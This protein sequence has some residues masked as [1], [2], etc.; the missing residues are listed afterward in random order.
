MSSASS[1]SMQPRRF[2]PSGPLKGTIRVPG[3]KSISHRSI[4]FGALAV[5]DTRISGLL[6]GEDV[7]ATAAAM[8][9]M[10]ARV[11]RIG[12]G[13]W[14]VSG[15]GVGSLLQ[16][17]TALDMGNSGTSTRLLM[18]LVASHPITASFIGDA[19]L[20]KRPMGRV[21]EPLG[22][23]GA[24]FTTSPGGTL[25]LMVRGASPAVPITEPSICAR[26]AEVTVFSE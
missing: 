16:P 22:K 3:D 21:T 18:G 17:E 9:A 8:R 13:D 1:A 10:G 6:E 24:D 19:S 7:M 23:M 15:V 20:S 14:R 2:L 26:A 4:M 25:P 5:G 12:E 11:E